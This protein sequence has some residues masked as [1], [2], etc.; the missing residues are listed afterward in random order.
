MWGLDFGTRTFGLRVSLGVYEFRVVRVSGFGFR[1]SGFRSLG[2]NASPCLVSPVPGLCRVWCL[3][4][5]VGPSM[6]TSAYD[7]GSNLN[8][9]GSIKSK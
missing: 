8:P 6:K 4:G 1:A 3:G 7:T 9:K 5:P 2:F